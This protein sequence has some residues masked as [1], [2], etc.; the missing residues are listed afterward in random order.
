MQHYPSLYDKDMPCGLSLILWHEVRD[1]DMAALM[2]SPADSPRRSSN[3]PPSCPEGRGREPDDIGAT[4]AVGIALKSL[5][6][7]VSSAP[8]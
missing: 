3:D 2:D 4:F 7:P 5:D 1:R 6:D 8:I